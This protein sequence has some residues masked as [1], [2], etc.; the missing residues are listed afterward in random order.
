MTKRESRIIRSMLT[1]N[2]FIA[3][4][5]KEFATA[6]DV[7]TEIMRGEFAIEDQSERYGVDFCWVFRRTLPSR[8]SVADEAKI[9]GFKH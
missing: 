1:R 5:L 3:L 7:L 9:C 4:N 8:I 6:N 2:L